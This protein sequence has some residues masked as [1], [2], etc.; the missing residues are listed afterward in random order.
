MCGRFIVSSWPPASFRL[1]FLRVIVEINSFKCFCCRFHRWPFGKS[2]SHSSRSGGLKSYLLDHSLKFMTAFFALKESSRL[3]Y[4]SKAEDLYL[5]SRQR[6]ILSEAPLRR[7]Y[8]NSS[9]A[10]IASCVLI[11][12]RH[13]NVKYQSQRGSSRAVECMNNSRTRAIIIFIPLLTNKACFYFLFLSQMNWVR[14]QFA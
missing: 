10:K 11:F 2:S 12:F 8:D 14:S 1:T 7:F 4:H 13:R 5:S 9:Y 3:C 6:C